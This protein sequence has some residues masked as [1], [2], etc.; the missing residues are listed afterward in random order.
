MKEGPIPGVVLSSRVTDGIC[1]MFAS[2]AN[3][4][5]LVVGLTGA[6]SECCDG[7]DEWATGAVCAQIGKCCNLWCSH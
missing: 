6:N 2:F 1:G 3:G 7:S 5:L 4:L